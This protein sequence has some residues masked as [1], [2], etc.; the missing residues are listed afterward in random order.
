M[1]KLV[2]LTVLLLSLGITASADHDQPLPPGRG[3]RRALLDEALNEIYSAKEEARYLQSRFRVD[4]RNLTI[5]LDQA[6]SL[7]EQAKRGGNR[8]PQPPPRSNVIELYHSDSCSGGL[9]GIVNYRSNCDT[10]FRGSDAWGIKV[11]GRCLNI[12]DM[13]ASR[14]CK[15]FRDMHEGSTLIYHSDSCSGGL[16]AAVD[17]NTDC[18]DL[19]G[20]SDAWGIQRPGRTCENIQDMNIVQACERFR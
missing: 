18:R 3:D 4:T 6:E 12:A 1:K 7:I 14:A 5:R 15:A 19:A 13:P 20:L 2:S 9:I 11:N 17:Y 8:P 10:D 16:V